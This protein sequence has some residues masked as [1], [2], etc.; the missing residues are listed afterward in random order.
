LQVLGSSPGFH[1]ARA[2]CVTRRLGSGGPR[3]R[4]ADR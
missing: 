4:P 3:R 1:P 2:F